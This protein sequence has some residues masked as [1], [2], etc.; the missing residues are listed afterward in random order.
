MHCLEPGCVDACPVGAIRKTPAGAVVYD[1]SK[2]MGCRYCMLACPLG[3]PRYEWEKKLPYMRKCDMCFDRLRE[4]RVPACVEACP[5]G[6]CV[7]GERD[8]LL[9]LAKGRVAGGRSPYLPHVYGEHELGG[10]SVLYIS[11]VP[12]E[13][14]GWPETVGSRTVSSY[15]WP[16]ISKT[17]WVAGGVA[18]FLAGTFFIIRRRMQLQGESAVPE[19]KQA[20]T[21]SRPGSRS[22]GGQQ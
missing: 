7:A 2:C 9:R 12:L 15:T 16:V 21:G 22:R 17:P 3:V 6:A 5:N 18:A 4:G 8:E 11:D 13:R 14:F 1:R 19:E 20:A 10:T